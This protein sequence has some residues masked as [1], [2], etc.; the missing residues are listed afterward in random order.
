MKVRPSVT[1]LCADSNQ[2]TFIMTSEHFYSSNT[3]NVTSLSCFLFSS[4][5]KTESKTN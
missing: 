5:A 1:A 4:V 3:L 2:E